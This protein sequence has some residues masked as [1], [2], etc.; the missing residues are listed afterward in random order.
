M[1]P[2]KKISVM[3]V[4]DD[5]DFQFLI[6]RAILREPDMETAGCFDNPAAAVRAALQ[7]PPD[8]VLMDLSLGKSVSEGISASRPIRLATDS[9]VLILTSYENPTTVVEAA[10]NSLAHGYLFKSHFDLLIETIRK[11]AAGA[12]PQEFMIE[13]LLLSRLSPAERSVF[14]IMIGRDVTLHSSPK[15]ISNQKTMVLKKL[16]FSSQNELMHIFAD[17]DEPYSP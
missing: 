2:H 11:T 14:E 10:V 3:I 15:T 1:N 17:P 6:R 16:G 5:M 12:T 7:R 4:E 13:T 8:I 9:K